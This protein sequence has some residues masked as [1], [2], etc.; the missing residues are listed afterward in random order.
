MRRY[1]ALHLPP[2]TVVAFTADIGFLMALTLRS[3]GHCGVCCE[4]C[5]LRLCPQSYRLRRDDIVAGHDC[6]NGNLVLAEFAPDSHNRAGLYCEPRRHDG[7][8]VV[9]PANSWLAPTA[10]S[11]RR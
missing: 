1:G 5:A 11:T 3:V 2:S 7:P 8:G 10:S 9:R 4:P 6:G